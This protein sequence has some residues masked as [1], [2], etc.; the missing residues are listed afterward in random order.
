MFS[1]GD[2]GVFTVPVRLYANRIKVS[3]NSAKHFASIVTVKTG[4]RFI[5]SDYAKVQS[6]SVNNP[7][8]HELFL[9]NK[10]LL[11]NVVMT[12]TFNRK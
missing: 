6:I 12:I 11:I 3:T 10:K 7:F 2:V 8:T 9:V 4:F 1:D 5:T